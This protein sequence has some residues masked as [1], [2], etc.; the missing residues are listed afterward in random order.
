MP[1]CIST[2]DDYITFLEA[3]RRYK[4]LKPEIVELMMTDRLT[5]EQ[6]RTFWTR[7]THG[8]GLG[9]RCPKGDEK[10]NEFGWGGAAGAFLVIDVQNAISIY[11][12]THILSSPAAG[13]R[14]KLHRFVRA[15]L[16]DNS[17]FES[18]YKELKDLY[19]YN[20]TY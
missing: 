10:Y 6:K 16:F 18:I 11:L 5:D 3:L 4:L 9:V 13:L 1:R 7:A 14:T 15:E 2:V 12:A 20:L 8:Y 17:D 19:D